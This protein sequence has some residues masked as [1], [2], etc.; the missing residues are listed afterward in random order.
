MYSP[1]AQM[2]ENFTA[3]CQILY[4]PGVPQCVLTQ[5]NAYRHAYCSLSLNALEM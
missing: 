4:L 5:V 1:K 2:H 3:L